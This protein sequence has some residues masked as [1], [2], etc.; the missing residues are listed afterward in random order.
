[1]GLTVLTT[2][3]LMLRDAARLFRKSLRSF[4]AL[5]ADFRFSSAHAVID[6]ID[7]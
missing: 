3:D 2:V 5:I 1:M 7:L 6:A 4:T